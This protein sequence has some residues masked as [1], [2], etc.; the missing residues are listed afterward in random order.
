MPRRVHLYRGQWIGLPLLLLLPVL[1]MAGVFGEG[2]STQTYTDQLV[3]FELDY[4]TRLRARQHSHITVRVERLAGNAADTIRV[5]F[6]PAWLD[7]FTELTIVPEPARPW[8]VELAGLERGDTAVVRVG[9]EANSHWRRS[10]RIRLSHAGG[11]THDVATT[12]FI[13]P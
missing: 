8:I 6:D 13:F 5:E 2:R 10:G 1:A 4:P 11:A 12:T 3:R 7:H 9:L